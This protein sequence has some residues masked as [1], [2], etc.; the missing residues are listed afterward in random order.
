MRPHSDTLSRAG[1]RAT[2]FI[3]LIEGWLSCELISNFCRG[4]AHE[5]P[6]SHLSSRAGYRATSL[7][8][9][10]EGWLLCDLFNN[11]YR[12][13]AY[14]NLTPIFHRSV[15]LSE[16]GYRAN[17]LTSSVR[18]RIAS[19]LV[20]SSPVSTIML[21]SHSRDR[22]HE[23]TDL[24]LSTTTIHSHPSPVDPPSLSII[25]KLSFR[26]RIIPAVS[27]EVYYLHALYTLYNLYICAHLIQ[28]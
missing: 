9:L 21:P 19:D 3:L 20:I 12:G 1:F 5:Q 13:L 10:T 22:L 7:P 27:S 14:V 23:K 17:S 24:S 15:S 6:Q 11:L 26:T 16:V 4:P 25:N 28:F 18:A 8:C 2:S